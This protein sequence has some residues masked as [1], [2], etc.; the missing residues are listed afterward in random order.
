M[1]LPRDTIPF[2]TSTLRSLR[3][4][5]STE[6]FIWK[7]WPPVPTSTIAIRS[8]HN[9]CLLPPPPIYTAFSL[10]ILTTL[11]EDIHVKLSASV[12]M[13]KYNF[14]CRGPFPATNCSPNPSLNLFDLDIA[15]QWLI[16]NAPKIGG[17]GNQVVEAFKVLG[18][19]LY[20]SQVNQFFKQHPNYVSVPVQGDTL[21]WMQINANLAVT[22]WS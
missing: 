11:K 13:L 20:L 21:A 7:C 6:P 17:S 1:A 14:E 4:I 15:F 2:T 22:D 8:A 5:P 3:T 18:D 19:N 10:Q 16:T 9:T 12:F